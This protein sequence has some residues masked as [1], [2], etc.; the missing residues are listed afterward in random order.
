MTQVTDRYR[1]PVIGFDTPKG[2]KEKIVTKKGNL[3]GGV[4]AVLMMGLMACSEN[5]SPSQ[6]LQDL[7]AK[8]DHAGLETW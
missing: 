6:G 8:N 3:L 7:V 4:I 1:Q 2:R 5:S